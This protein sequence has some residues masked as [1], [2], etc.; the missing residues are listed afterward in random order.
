[1]LVARVEPVAQAEGRLL[2]LVVLV[3]LAEG[4]PFALVAL[5]ALAELAPLAEG[6]PSVRT[7]ACQPAAEAKGA[8][9][10]RLVSTLVVA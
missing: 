3:E 2:A 8:V 6:R 1:M 4:R 10:H 7:M 5:V 9:R